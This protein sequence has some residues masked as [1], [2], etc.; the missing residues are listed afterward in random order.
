M[1]GCIT[2]DAHHN[3][4]ETLVSQWLQIVIVMI[5]IVVMIKLALVLPLP[6]H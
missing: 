2:P 1:R 3:H 5:M 4:I 6:A